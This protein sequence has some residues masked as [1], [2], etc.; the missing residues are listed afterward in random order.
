MYRKLVL[1]IVFTFFII[2]GFSQTEV[3]VHFLGAEGKTAHIW[4]Y[5]DYVSYLRKE[6]S[7]HKIDSKGSFSFKLYIHNPKPI[8]IQVGFIRVQLFLEPKRDYS[9]RIEPVDFS[10]ESIYPSDQ[11]VYL[12]P[13]YKILKPV[14]HELNDGIAQSEALFSA[15]IDSNYLSLIRGYNTKLLVDSFA[16]KMDVFLNNFGNDYLKDYT[17]MQMAQLR[18]LSHE[19]TNQTIIDKYFS[20]KNLNLN[21]P[22][23]MRFFNSYWSH[24]ITNKAKGFSSR[25]LDSTINIAKSYMELSALLARDPLLKDSTLREL[26]ILRN[27]I[28][29]YP[30]R[31]FSKSAL[32]DI[33]YDIS[34]SNLRPEHRMIAV[35]VRKRLQRFS[36]GGEL[37]NAKFTDIQGHDFQLKDFKGKYVYINVWDLDCPSC[38]A[39]MNYTKELFE[40]FDDII[41]FVSISV[42]RDTAEMAAYVKDKDYQ[43]TIAPLG[44][45][46][47]FL[48]DYNIGVLP[49]YILINKE[50]KLEMLDAPTPSNHFAERF[51]K[52]L[53]DKKGNLKVKDNY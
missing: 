4:A 53:N 28:Q 8:F 33:L 52:M 35:N 37:P 41:Q 11:I 39:E 42:D 25:T 5:T 50:G 7:T 22:S 48:N 23:L 10:D 34:R 47:Q 2:S 51:L 32:I 31:R 43:W 14:E 24:Y 20:G 40:D 18:L 19:Y 21:D 45:N 6:L 49:R 26:V 1:S 38:L 44:E 15:F 17:S 29:M 30:N 36:V 46:F 9:I 16:R 12:A 3:K 13:K 27:I